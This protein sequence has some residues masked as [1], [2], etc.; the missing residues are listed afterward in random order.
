MPDGNA[1]P[2]GPGVGSQNASSVSVSRP[3]GAHGGNGGDGPLR[4]GGLTEDR[5]VS[6]GNLT[7]QQ[8]DLWESAGLTLWPQKI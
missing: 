4:N 7:T 1:W 5:V 2:E 3:L 8:L 6:N